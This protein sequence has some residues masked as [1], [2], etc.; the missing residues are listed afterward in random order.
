M[1]PRVEAFEAA[2]AEHLGCRHAVAV[3]SCTAALHLA[4]LAAGVGPG[5]EVIVPSMTFAATAN[6]V[7][8]CGGTPVFADILGPHDLA[9]RSRARRRADR[10]AHA[11][12]SPSCTS[13]AIPAPVDAA[14]RAVRRARAR[15]DRGRRARAERATSGGRKL[16]HVRPG[17]GVLVLLQQGARVRRG[18][19]AGHRR[20]RGRRRCAARVQPWSRTASDLRRAGWVNYR[21]DEPRAALLLSRLRRLEDDIA[22]RRELVRRY[23]ERL[24]GI[25]GVIVPYRGRRPWRTRRAT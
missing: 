25:D 23:R 17:R 9:H 6:A 5:D 14:A 22:R 12:P 15:A 11:R 21:M 16:G 7:L 8:Y 18:R 2:F 10:P 4:Y 3:S 20:R 24:A 1:G 19:P 13:P